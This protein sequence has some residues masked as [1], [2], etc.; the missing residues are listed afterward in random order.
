MRAKWSSLTFIKWTVATVALFLL[1]PDTWAKPKFKVLAN[2]PGGLWSGLT[3]DAKGNLYGVTSG[4]GDYGEGSVFELSRGANGKWTVT[5]LH[6]FDGTDG[7]SPT[8]SLVFDAA[9]NLYG[10]APDGGAYLYGDVFELSS[11]S[12]GWTFNVIYDFC[13]QFDCPDG[14]DPVGLLVDRLGHLYGTASMGIYDSGVVYELTN[15]GSGWGQSVLYTFDGLKTGMDPG[16][17]LVFDA[18]RRIYGATWTGGPYGGSGTVFR[19]S[20][21]PGGAW[22]QHALY[23]FCK[24]GWPCV[25]GF[26]PEGGLVLDGTA[27]IYGATAQGG[28]HTCGETNCGTVFGLSQTGSGPWKEAV[29]YD[30]RPGGTGNGPSGGVVLDKKGNLYGTAVNGGSGGCGYGCGVVY[31]LTPLGQNKWQYSVVHAFT[32][33]DGGNPQG[34]LIFDKNGS[35]Y[36]TALSTAWEIT[37]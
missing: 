35:L 22:K 7:S 26:R 23:D 8:G 5:T 13:Q 19:L 32:G 20:H 31:K 11:G 25:D 1:L 37:P 36:G 33:Q 17:P 6:S 10:T 34:G 29:L 18:A 4:G 2:V 21:R 9:G 3:M 28:S 24:K 27:K 15:S 30:F 12:G 14:A 16:G